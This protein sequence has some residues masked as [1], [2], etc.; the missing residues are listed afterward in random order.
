MSTQMNVK[1]LILAE[2]VEQESAESQRKKR[3]IEAPSFEVV[4]NSGI[5]FAVRRKT[6]KTSRLLVLLVSQQQYYI[7]DENKGEI[8]A[9]DSKGLGQFLKGCEY[10][11][12]RID[13]QWCSRLLKSKEWRDWFVRIITHEKFVDVAKSGIWDAA[14]EANYSRWQKWNNR[15]FDEIVETSAIVSSALLSYIRELTD[16]L[17]I[18]VAKDLLYSFSIIETVYGLDRARVYVKQIIDC[19]LND[20][21]YSYPMARE[22]ERLLNISPSSAV[23]FYNYHRSNRSMSTDMA[24]QTIFEGREHVRF[25]FNRFLDYLFNQSQAEGFASA[26]TWVAYWADTLLLE[27]HV[28]DRI[29]NKYPSNLLTYHNILATEAAAIK[30]DYD[31]I[32]FNEQVEVMSKY[33]YSNNNYTIICPK[34][35]EDMRKE[36]AAQSNCLASYVDTVIAGQTM[37]FFCRK[38]KNAEKSY[39]TIEV[40]DNQLWQV[41]ASH[42][43]EADE[44]GMSFIKK[45]VDNFGIEYGR[46]ENVFNSME[47]LNKVE[48]LLNAS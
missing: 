40:K 26:D 32:A 20:F 10:D 25:D 12:L 22:L 43:R 19:L 8:T 3:A 14:D 13:N 39:L 31:L 15:V 29:V 35:A 17:P 21:D 4:V 45:W 11:R 9:L 44:E 41:K 38:N 47:R 28:A 27:L 42:N 23:T 30:K 37:I 34:S 5:D 36:A 7:K 1:D 48:T 33:E 18:N 6:S 2:D 16:G 24:H 46:Y